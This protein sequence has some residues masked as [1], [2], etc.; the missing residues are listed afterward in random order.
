MHSSVFEGKIC[1][2]CSVVIININDIYKDIETYMFGIHEHIIYYHN[3]S[4][5]FQI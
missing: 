1:I 4:Y 5:I 3:Q 2:L